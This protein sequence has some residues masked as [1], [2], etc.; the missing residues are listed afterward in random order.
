VQDWQN[1][2]NGALNRKAV[3]LIMDKRVIL[4]RIEN[5]GRPHALILRPKTALEMKAG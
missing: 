2:F 1:E 3:Q 5:H 4:V